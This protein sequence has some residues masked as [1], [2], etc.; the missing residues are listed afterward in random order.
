MVATPILGLISQ[1][2]GRKEDLDGPGKMVC[3]ETL[4]WK[5][6]TPWLIIDNAW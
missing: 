4:C 1:R 5:W 3:E 2:D 6:A